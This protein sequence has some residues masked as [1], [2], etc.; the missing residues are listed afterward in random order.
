MSQLEIIVQIIKKLQ[1]FLVDISRLQGDLLF[2]QNNLLFSLNV[3]NYPFYVDWQVD[4]LDLIRL[5]EDSLY[6]ASGFFDFRV[7]LLQKMLGEVLWRVNIW[8]SLKNILFEDVFVIFILFVKS[9]FFLQFCIVHQHELGQISLFF[10]ELSSKAILSVRELQDPLGAISNCSIIA[11]LE[12][13]N[14]FN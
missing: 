13:F 10:Y 7:F 1:N 2:V 5:H 6:N 12:I 3:L 4:V 8:K 14:G 11:Y 9:V